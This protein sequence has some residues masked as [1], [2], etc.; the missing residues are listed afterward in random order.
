MK[1]VLLLVLVLVMA[2]SCV[3]C[4]A[5]NSLNASEVSSLRWKIAFSFQEGIDSAKS[6]FDEDYSRDRY[7]GNFSLPHNKDL[8]VDSL[9]SANFKDVL[10]TK[11]IGDYERENNVSVDGIAFDV[12]Y[13]MGEKSC[14][15][16]YLS[17]E[18]YSLTDYNDLKKF[19]IK[20]YGSYNNDHPSKNKSLWYYPDGNNTI[21]MCFIDDEKAS[22][23][24]IFSYDQSRAD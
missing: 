7:T 4:G 24:M 12:Y 18:N 10:K 5:K 1:K 17:K 13:S 21:S 19:M 15:A 23:G 8:R 3:G 11:H 14:Y 22:I 16:I 2:V 6:V 9:T 20:Q